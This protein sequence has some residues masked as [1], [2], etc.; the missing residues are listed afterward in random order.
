MTSVIR[1]LSTI[2]A[3]VASLLPVA[4]AQA[5]Q[6]MCAPRDV[7][8]AAIASHDEALIMRGIIGENMLEIWRDSDGGFTITLHS[9]SG[10]TCIVAFGEA[11]HDAEPSPPPPRGPKS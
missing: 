1:R 3:L 9:P 5:Q 7:V 11:L 4:A 6:Q 2:A 8:T 10:T